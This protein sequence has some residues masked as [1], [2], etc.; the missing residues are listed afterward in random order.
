MEMELVGLADLGREIDVSPQGLAN[1]L[2]QGRI[3]ATQYVWIG[4]RRLIRRSAIP[5]IVASMAT[6]KR[7]KKRT[8]VAV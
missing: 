1:M 6:I 8:R 7:R 4:G 3:N 2:Y 5:A